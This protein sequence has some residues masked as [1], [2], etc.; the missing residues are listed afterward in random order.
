MGN[1]FLLKKGAQI[2]KA[3]TLK[4]RRLAQSDLF[5]KHP[6]CKT[7]SIIA[8]V[9]Q[10]ARVGPNE[11]VLLQ[12]SGSRLVILRDMATIAVHEAP[13][14]DVYAAIRD[15]A[16]CAIGETLRV[17]ALSGTVEVQIKK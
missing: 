12:C 9:L 2:S 17:N 14:P 6:E 10:G 15:S 8:D 5:T 16:G 7:R 13:P 4:A 1:E 11:A 3:L